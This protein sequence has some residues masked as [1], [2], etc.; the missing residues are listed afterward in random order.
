MTAPYFHD[1][2][3]RALTDVLK[4][5]TRGGND[6]PMRDWELQP[7]DLDDLEQQDIIEFLKSLTSDHARQS[8]QTIKP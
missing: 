8:D 2:S 4:F 7:L 3:A 6:N 5:Y 1:G